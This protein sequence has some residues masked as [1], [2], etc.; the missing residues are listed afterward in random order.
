MTQSK[1]WVAWA[2]EAELQRLKQRCALPAGEE[3]RQMWLDAQHL[4]TGSFTSRNQSLR[5][6]RGEASCQHDQD[7][8]C[9]DDSIMVDTSNAP[10]RG[11][12]SHAA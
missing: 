9:L 7:K 10:W 1:R 4:P 6:I 3:S 11:S 12:T 5:S 8:K 2:D